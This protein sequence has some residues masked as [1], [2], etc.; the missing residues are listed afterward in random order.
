M[1]LWTQGSAI[2]WLRLPLNYTLNN[3][4][5]S[6]TNQHQVQFWSR[7]ILDIDFLYNF[8]FTTRIGILDLVPQ[9][10]KLSERH[11][12]FEGEGG[13]AHASRRERRTG[14]NRIGCQR[15]LLA[16]FL[17]GV[18]QDKIIQCGCRGLQATASPAVSPS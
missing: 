8:R 4:I 9:S 17:G 1:G 16:F 3:L 7:F 6:D 11:C 10:D 15:E 18:E 12:Q 2:S 14:R 13:S 5:L